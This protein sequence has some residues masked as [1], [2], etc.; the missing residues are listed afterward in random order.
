MFDRP[1]G[2][3]DSYTSR[4]TRTSILYT[5]PLL[6]THTHTHATDKEKIIYNNI[7]YTY[8]CMY[9]HI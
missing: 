6:H 5:G 7:I 4:E 2:F 1:T 8:V 3:R 9:A